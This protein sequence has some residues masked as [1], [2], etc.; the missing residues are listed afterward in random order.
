MSATL[1]GKAL[2]S[3]ELAELAERARTVTGIVLPLMFRE[4]ETGRL[5]PHIRIRP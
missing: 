1:S 4:P 5:D 2:I 3:S